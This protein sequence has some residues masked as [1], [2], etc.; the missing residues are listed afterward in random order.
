M[1]KLLQRSSCIER[2]KTSQ[3]KLTWESRADYQ[4]PSSVGSKKRVRMLLAGQSKSASTNVHEL[5]SKRVGLSNRITD[6]TQRA[7]IGTSSKDYGQPNSDLSPGV[8]VSSLP[9]T[10]PSGPA[11]VNAVPAPQMPCMCAQPVAAAFLLALNN[12][13]L[14][15]FHQHLQ[16][17]ISHAIPIVPPAASPLMSA[18]T[19]PPARAGKLSDS[20]LYLHVRQS[21]ADNTDEASC[22]GKEFPK[23]SLLIVANIKNPVAFLLRSDQ[24]SPSIHPHHHHVIRACAC[25]D[26]TRVS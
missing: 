26:V 12:P 15:A 4:I 6:N 24:V 21:I 22:I 16:S 23:S 18:A 20:D 7:S 10:L 17:L 3:D 5:S 11:A 1:T 13:A 19:R 9:C 14:Q 8:R 2:G 25:A